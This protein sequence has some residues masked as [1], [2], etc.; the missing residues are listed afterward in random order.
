VWHGPGQVKAS[1]P[2]ERRPPPGEKIVDLREIDFMA[3]LL[4]FKHQDKGC[5]FV[6]VYFFNRVHDDPN[7]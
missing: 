5:V 3:S 2:R 7:F 4:R 1:I 6:D